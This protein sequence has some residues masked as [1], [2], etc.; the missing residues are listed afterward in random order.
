MKGY[1]ETH[2]RGR[3]NFSQLFKTLVEGRPELGVAERASEIRKA[4]EAALTDPEGR[5]LAGALGLPPPDPV[6]K[7]IKLVPRVRRAQ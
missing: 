7:P 1:G 6:T 5:A 4:R 2:K 3:A